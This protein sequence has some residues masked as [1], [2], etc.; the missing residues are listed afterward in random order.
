MSKKITIYV[1]LLLSAAVSSSHADTI[2]TVGIAPHGGAV[3]LGGSVIP[4]KEVTL[5]AQMPGRVIS[6]AGEEGDEFM[7]GALLLSLNDDGLQESANR[8]KLN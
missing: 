8:Q 6:I 1:L 3:I 4:L 5:A 2:V 7:A